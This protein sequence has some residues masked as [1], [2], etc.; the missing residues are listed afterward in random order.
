MLALLGCRS[1]W[2]WRQ[3]PT[4]M[5]HHDGLFGRSHDRPL[6]R[7]PTYLTCLV[8][9]RRY[10]PPSVRSSG[11][12]PL[13]ERWNGTAWSI[14][15]VPKPRAPGR[16]FLR[17]VSCTSRSDCVAVGSIRRRGR[18]KRSPS[19]GMAFGGRSWRPPTLRGR[20]TARSTACR[21]PDRTGASPSDLP[22]D[23]RGESRSRSDSPAA[24]GPSNQPP[25]S[26][27]PDRTGSP[28][29]N[30]AFRSVSCTSDTAC[31]A[32]GS[33]RRARPRLA[34][35]R[36]W[37][38]AGTAPL[39]RSRQVCA[40]TSTS[41][42][43]TFTAC[44]AHRA[45]RAPWSD[46]PSSKS[47]D[48]CRLRPDGTAAAGRLESHRRRPTPLRRTSST[49]TPPGSPQRVLHDRQ[50]LHDG[51]RKWTYRTG[52]RHHPVDPT[53]SAAA[54]NRLHRRVVRNFRELHRGRR[55][56]GF[57][58]FRPPADTV[59]RRPRLAGQPA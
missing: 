37:P 28:P 11:G 40:T 58:G 9:R 23:R 13:A 8:P 39:G 44:H 27:I 34:F 15:S 38:N 7:A 2:S 45:R 30:D 51:R 59:S 17:A 35:A 18:R 33:P 1:C 47:S 55:Q 10:V 56:R 32:V 25:R 42:R 12:V 52:E 48:M 24:P 21:A 43:S 57:N 53:R 31:M 26:S 14:Q 46:R 20:S 3:T 6:Q 41:S 5:D 4:R 22:K 16:S 19:A 54:R 36:R 49:D 29:R 50:D